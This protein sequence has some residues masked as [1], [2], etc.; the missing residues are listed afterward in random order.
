MG[1]ILHSCARTTEAMRR[2]I[3]NSKESLKMLSEKYSVNPKTIRKWKSRDYVHD[4]PMG[5]KN[6]HS[7]TLSRE[8]E[9]VCVAFR[10]HTLLPLDDCLY[11]LQ[12]SIPHLTRS[13]LHRLFQ[14]NDISRLPELDE[15]KREK[16]NFKQYPIGYFHIDIAEVRTEEGK[17]YLF[18]AIDRT[19]K[20]V[21]TE[22][23]EK[24]GKMQAAQFLRNLIALVPY[25]IHTILTDNGV[26][27]TNLQHQK[28]ALPHIFGRVCEEHNIDHRRT[29][30]AHPWT[31]GQ[32]ERM[33]KTIKEATVKRYHYNS[34]EQLREHLKTFIDAYNFAKRLKTLKGLTPYEF[35]IKTWQN[36]PQLFVSDPSHLN[37]EPYI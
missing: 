25:K 2:A 1:Q 22:F 34:H 12:S 21:Y 27:F 31:N 35:I 37:P 18:V 8:E 30:P 7:T 23:L 14:R 26:Q 10:R 28:Y 33:N 4:S 5:P 29:Q 15:K 19:S 6:P 16:K 32:V 13:S 36:E 17:L 24:A 3:Q 11:A 9:A 20:F